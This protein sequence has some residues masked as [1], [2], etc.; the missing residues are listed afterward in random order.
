MEDNIKKNVVIYKGNEYDLS[1]PSIL[2]D[3]LSN[4]YFHIIESV[5]IYN[6]L[7]V[8]K[9]SVTSARSPVY[10]KS[11]NLEKYIEGN[12]IIKVLYGTDNEYLFATSNF[13]NNGD[14]NLRFVP[15][16]NIYCDETYFKNNY[17]LNKFRPFNNI[18]KKNN[19]IYNEYLDESSKK[20]LI[21][22]D[23]DFGV[24]TLT[25]KIF[26]G[27]EYTYGIELETM[28]GRVNEKEAENLNLLCEFDGSLREHPDQRK[29]DVLGSEYV[30]GVMIGDSGMYQIQKILNVLSEKCTIGQKAGLHVHIGNIKFT[31]ENI[32]YL[33]ILALKLEKEIFEILPPSRQ[34][35]SYCKPLKQ[36]KFNDL[37][38]GLSEITYK[39]I[40]NDYFNAIFKYVSNGSEPDKKFNKKSNHPLGSKCGYN[41]ETQRYCWLNFVT[42]MFNTKNNPEAMTLEFRC[43]NSTLNYTK[44]KNWIKICVAFVNFAESQKTAIMNNFW[45]D[46]NKEEKPICLETII[47]AT[48]PKTGKLIIDYISKRKNKF[49]YKTEESENLEYSSDKEELNNLLTLKE[50]ICV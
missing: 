22:R 41:K 44:V 10:I 43:H 20:E 31:K 13:Y 23:L 48:Y 50:S 33:Y 24:R 29:E 12:N 11:Q 39:L 42:A 18:V 16:D 15:T 2:K 26:E 28:S 34:K 7:I 17:S 37:K 32:V 30:T 47:Q 38:T 46:K 49:F 40:I 25:N 8:R 3:H 9:N 14:C 21:K 5:K 4:E 1:H 27:L 45:I 35:N 6:S 19:D 36:I